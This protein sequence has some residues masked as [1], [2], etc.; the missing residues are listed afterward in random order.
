MPVAL[1]HEEKE[2]KKKK[3]GMSLYSPIFV[4]FQSEEKCYNPSLSMKMPVAL[5]HEEIIINKK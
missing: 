3:R 5:L 1:L 4:L 2:K